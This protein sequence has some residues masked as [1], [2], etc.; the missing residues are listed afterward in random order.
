MGLIPQTYESAGLLVGQMVRVQ[1]AHG[2]G[3][4]FCRGRGLG[5]LPKHP[6]KPRHFGKSTGF[7]LDAGGVAVSFGGMGSSQA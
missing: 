6:L 3:C 4:G 7:V 2:T 1:G 5:F